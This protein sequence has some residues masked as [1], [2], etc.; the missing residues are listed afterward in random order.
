[1]FCHEDIPWHTNIKERPEHEEKTQKGINHL[2]IGYNNNNNNNSDDNRRCFNHIIA[3]N[4]DDNDTKNMEKK[5]KTN[6]FGDNNNGIENKH[7]K[8]NQENTQHQPKVQKNGDDQRNP[9]D[10]R[11]ESKSIVEIKNTTNRDGM[12]LECSHHGSKRCRKNVAIINKAETNHNHECV[13]H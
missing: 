10:D 2:K 9:N 1:M 3:G 5:E 6:P 8:H 13:L 12:I 7:P 11:E 4:N